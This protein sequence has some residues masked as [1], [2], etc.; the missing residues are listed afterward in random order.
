M[1]QDYFG[2]EVIGEAV[3]TLGNVHMDP[4][5]AS[6]N[7]SGQGDPFVVDTA[8]DSSRN[9][10]SAVGWNNGMYSPAQDPMVFSWESCG[11]T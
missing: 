6:G 2:N 1:N 9:P 3:D 7:S 4:G 10:C 5:A 8:I 11:P